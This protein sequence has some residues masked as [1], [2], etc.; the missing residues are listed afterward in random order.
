MKQAVTGAQHCVFTMDRHCVL[1][2]RV[3]SAWAKKTKTKSIQDKVEVAAPQRCGQISNVL[4][5]G[6]PRESLL[7]NTGF[8]IV[9][10]LTSL[11]MRWRDSS[12][13]SSHQRRHLNAKKGNSPSNDAQSKKGALTICELVQSVNLS[14]DCPLVNTSLWQIKQCWQSKIKLFFPHCTWQGEGFPFGKE[15]PWKQMP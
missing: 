12:G 1:R 7:A 3:L 10:I 13:D 9:S 15:F 11:H 14:K 4:Y 8:L 2:Y 6:I 5:A